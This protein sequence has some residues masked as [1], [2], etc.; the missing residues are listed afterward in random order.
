MFAIEMRSRSRCDEKLKKKTNEIGRNRKSSQ[1]GNKKLI[2]TFILKYFRIMNY[3]FC[4]DFY[5]SNL[6]M[7]ARI[8]K[9]KFAGTFCIY[10][11]VLSFLL[12][13]EFVLK[14]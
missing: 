13:F 1:I 3:S 14:F 7:T 12:N 6:R 4:A 9:E 8:K 10:P 5:E 11:S 2:C